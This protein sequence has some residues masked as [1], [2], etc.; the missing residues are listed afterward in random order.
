M[1]LLTPKMLL[2]LDRK[3]TDLYEELERYPD[4]EVLTSEF[5]MA[6]GH[7][8]AARRALAAALRDLCIRKGAT[9]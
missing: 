1:A 9:T 2:L 6:H 5:M 3:S 4:D 7:Y 8:T